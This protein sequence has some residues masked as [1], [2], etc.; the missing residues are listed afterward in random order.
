MSQSYNNLA[1]ISDAEPIIYPS[2]PTYGC[3]RGFLAPPTV[4]LIPNDL[5]IMEQI[6][7]VTDMCEAY[8]VHNIF[9]EFPSPS[10]IIPHKYK[11]LVDQLQPASEEHMQH[12]R[13]AIH[14]CAKDTPSFVYQNKE[15]HQHNPYLTKQ[16]KSALT[17]LMSHWC[18]HSV[19]VRIMLGLHE[20][21]LTKNIDEDPNPPEP[22][23]PS[24]F[25]MLRCASGP[26]SGSDEY[27]Y[28]G[29]YITRLERCFGYEPHYYTFSTD[30]SDP[31]QH[32]VDGF[33]R[34]FGK[35]RLLP[36]L[37]DEADRL[38]KAYQAH[39]IQSFAN[40][41]ERFLGAVRHQYELVPQPIFDTP[42]DEDNNILSV[43]NPLYRYFNNDYVP[44][45]N[46]PTI[47]QETANSIPALKSDIQ[48]S[49]VMNLCA[50]INVRNSVLPDDVS[51]HLASFL[52]TRLRDTAPELLHRPRLPMYSN[53]NIDKIANKTI[54][55]LTV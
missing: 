14:Y 26:P 5:T 40:I 18:S 8:L 55:L 25:M 19:M 45:Y 49:F 46:V 35:Q 3:E 38:V 1:S 30:N 16:T 36:L 29:S 28:N 31:N 32:G 43:W 4:D 34:A 48:A 27:I 10:F 52:G 9:V 41:L 12:L 13:A 6:Q 53:E 17:G 44:Y 50:R 51:N 23:N 7:W 47:L 42:T 2:K 20:Y 33:L 21:V 54:A 24:N 39:P 15:P 22:F 11:V 37:Q